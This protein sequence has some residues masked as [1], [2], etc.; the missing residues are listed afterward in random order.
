MS[1]MPSAADRINAQT[2][3]MKGKDVVCEQCGSEHFYEIQV[4]RYL[5]GGSGSVEIQMDP[6]E[7]VHPLLK[8]AG[9]NFPVLPKPSV[10]RRHGGTFETSHKAFRDSVERGQG[11]MKA[12]TPKAVT[13]EILAAVAG[14]DVEPKVEGLIERVT[15]LE[16]DL[17]ETDPT[18]SKKQKPK[19]D[20]S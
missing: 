4:S 18:T 16:K 7:Q 6:N 19:E 17:G 14:K 3:Q 10:N 2:R 9:C 8:C 1:T 15:K 20:K 11:Y 13:N 12:S 5:S